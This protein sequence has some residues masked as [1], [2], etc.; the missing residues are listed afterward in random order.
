VQDHRSI[1]VIIP[2]RIGDVL[3]ATPLLRSLK[4]AWPESAIDVLVFQGTEGILA[5]HPDVRRVLVVAR[6][7]ALG[8]HARLLRTMFRRYDIA[9]SLLPGDRPTFYAWLAGRWRAGILIPG[10]RWAWKR[11]LLSR[12]VPSETRNWHTVRIYLRLTEVLGIPPRGEV[13]VGWSAEDEAAVTRIL[14]E[15]KPDGAF[16]VLHPS[17]KFN[18]KKW[19]ETGWV[20]VARDLAERD[21]RIILTGGVDPGERV[22]V[23][24]L[25]RRMPPGTVDTSGRLTLTQVACLLSRARIYVGPDTAVTHLAAAIGIPTVALYGPSDPVTWGPWPKGFPPDRNPWA[26][27]GSQTVGNVALV[28]GA[29]ECVPCLL[30]GCD[31]HSLSFSECL[32]TLPARRVIEAADRLMAEAAARPLAGRSDAAPERRVL[33]IPLDSPGTPC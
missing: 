23:A 30:E 7:P 29:G 12:W 27:V 5:A 8:E 24:T 18:Y 17:P 16:A 21:F 6:R 32:Q 19:H 22:E 26:P 33:G 11:A 10:L 9:L 3:L 31:R 20:E 13:T 15:A 2:Q 28:Q 1:L 25:A 4:A 14:D